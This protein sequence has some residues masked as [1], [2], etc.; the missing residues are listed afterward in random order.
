[1][2]PHSVAILLALLCVVSLFGP[3]TVAAPENEEIPQLRLAFE[4]ET[5]EV[6][7]L[8]NVSLF[9]TSNGRPV[10]PDFIPPPLRSI[11]FAVNSTIPI[12]QPPMEY[13]DLRNVTKVTD[14]EYAANFTLADHHVQRMLPFGG[15]IP[16]IGK[17]VFMM[18]MCSYTPIG[19]SD[20][21][22]VTSMGIISIEDG[23]TI[24]TAISDFYPEPGDTVD[25]TVSIKN[26]TPIDAKTVK[27]ELKSFD[28]QT[29]NVIGEL[30]VNNESVGV[31]KAS[32]T[33][34]VDLAMATDYSVHSSASF[35][36]YGDTNFISPIFDMGFT[37]R[38]FDLYFEKT[39]ES[40]GSTSMNAWVADLDGNALE[41]ITVQL[42][43]QTPGGLPQTAT[44]DTDSTGKTFFNLDHASA[45]RVDVWGSL[46]D[47][48]Y[49]Q[50]F[51][52]E[53]IVDFS[54]P[55]PN[56]P[57]EFE[58]LNVEPWDTPEGDTIF[59]NI[60]RP[61]DDV[62]TKFRV[63]NA[64]GEVVPDKRLNWYLLDRDGF[65]DT[66][67][68]VV[69]SGYVVTDSTGDFM[70]TYK[71]PPTDVNGWL[72]F[73]TVLWNP[74]K[75]PTGGYERYETSEPLFDAG[76]FPIDEG[77]ELS[78][79]RVTKDAPIELR[80]K[81]ALPPNS[82][83]GH[84]LTV[85]DEA[86]GE[87]DWGQPMDLGD[88]GDDFPVI[89][90]P[91]VGPAI[92]GL[93][94]QLPE[95][96]P[97]DQAIAFAAI[98]LDL[99][100]FKIMMNYVI[101]GYD[102][103]TIKGVDANV[104]VPPEA[105]NAGGTGDFE[106][107]VENTGAGRD[108]F[109][110]EQT[111]GPGSWL[112]FPTSV[113]VAASETESLTVNVTVPPDV[114]E[115]T[116]SFNLT[117]TSKDPDVSD[118]VEV[119][120]DV[121]V[122]GVVIRSRTSEDTAFRDETV[123]FIVTVNNT[124]QGNDTY[125]IS[126]EGTG[127]PWTST[128]HSSVTVPEGSEGEVVVQVAVPSDADE[129]AYLV[130]VTAT[131]SDGVTSAG[132][133]LT[134][135]VLVD[136]VTVVGAVDFE[137]TWPDEAVSFEFTVTNTGQGPDIFTLVLEGTQPGWGGISNGV[138][139]LEEGASE[140]V[141]VEVT[142]P[143]DPAEGFYD[144]VLRATSANGITTAT[145]Q[146]SVKIWVNS[147]V[148]NTDPGT[149]P[150]HRTDM[151]QVTLTITND[152]QGADVVTLSHEDSDWAELVT[153]ASNPVSVPEGGSVDVD[154]TVQLPT[155][156][157]EGT[158]FLNVIGTSEDARSTGTTSYRVDVTVN[159]VEATLSDV[160]K[161]IK[162][163]ERAKL[164]ITLTNTGQGEDTFT[165]SFVGSAGDW[166]TFDR[167]VVTL[168]EGASEDVT[169]TIKVPKK[170]KPGDAVLNVTVASA[171]TTF[172]DTAQ[173]QVVV[174]KADE[175]PGMGALAAIVAAALVGALMRVSTRRR[176]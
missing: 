51:Y 147:V 102:E 163:G 160:S 143:T 22:Q 148:V 63:Y 16:V 153:F 109:S 27:V 9:L 150:G 31:Y 142:A 13:W 95:F 164:T 64:T 28:G 54:V 2:R 132:V 116:Y 174:K 124:G 131:S 61:G 69:E 166:A 119:S 12:G 94:K 127:A 176:A 108:T 82:F 67:F 165:I 70:L 11:V 87:T 115:G 10:N 167:T 6:G 79:D 57:D 1:M 91:K 93:D 17:L 112:D 155:D 38:F 125:A 162:Q 73:E 156:I 129:G 43:Q 136:G 149:A 107:T 135:N 89:P 83:I 32:Y 21:V 45:E 98:T 14:G 19:A 78:V 111:V 117:V 145:A 175:S 88:S 113:T 5:Y 53:A 55:E 103:S 85:I 146:T 84:F 44:R 126:V 8:V 71:V 134:V 39:S 33:V 137:E 59:D 114:D 144:F 140:T 90:L 130:N 161:K 50:R 80:A 76:F 62:T 157:D 170:A 47:G 96:F 92:Y 105:V 24:E 75:E 15:G 20:S 77:I 128:G 138:L 4:R 35:S 101:V 172:I 7:E 65:L 81:V 18:A 49:T 3:A 139:A 171:D 60:K 41:G 118:V 121:L 29:E 154:M 52:M 48:T 151:L 158:Y 74:D 168:A 26:G 100:Q 40:A 169:V 25:I 23:P 36:D 133:T 46:T 152:G 34:P 173:F 106:L 159:G 42:T 68:T 104:P 97:E 123:D 122:N 56:V 37:V 120:V 72:M 58:D 86:T 30:R 99:T 110:V 141:T 66:D